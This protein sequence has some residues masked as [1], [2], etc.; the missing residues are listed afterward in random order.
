MAL[1]KRILVVSCVD[2]GP[3]CTPMLF[4]PE[5]QK[6]T[7]ASANIYGVDLPAHHVAGSTWA[8]VSATGSELAL[9]DVDTGLKKPSVALPLAADVVHGVAAIP[10]PGDRLA[11]VGS[12]P[13]AGVVVLVDLAPTPRVAR[14][15]TPPPCK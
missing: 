11:I 4:D 14:K 8:F 13:N 6:S 12:P 7:T 10:R 1:G 2:A 15:Y 5:T 3:G 9:V